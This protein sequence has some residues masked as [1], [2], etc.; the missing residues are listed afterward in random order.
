MRDVS[1]ESSEDKKKQTSFGRGR[2]R[3]WPPVPCKPTTKNLLPRQSA[4]TPRERGCRR[5][6]K[7]F[8]LSFLILG[9]RATVLIF[10][11]VPS[12]C[13]HLHFLLEKIS[14][15]QR[16]FSIGSINTTIMYRRFLPN[17]IGYTYCISFKGSCRRT[18]AFEEVRFNPY[19]ALC[20]NNSW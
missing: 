3:P 2:V 17:S 15:E 14:H 19:F 1:S 13:L 9:V 6:A 7:F 12:R 4:F 8:S 5:K 10:R 11:Y 16:N 18:K 20:R